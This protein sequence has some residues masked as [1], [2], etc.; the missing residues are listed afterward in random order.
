MFGIQ[1]YP[2]PP[3]LVKKMVNKL[4]FSKE[5]KSISLLE[6][7]AGKGNIID[8]FKCL[9]TGV[10]SV[11]KGMIGITITQMS[12]QV[13]EKG[14]IHNETNIYTEIQILTSEGIWV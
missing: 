13:F 11:E 1:F 7:S 5:T 9:Q 3:E 14:I 6:P 12:S 4:T 10:K 2:S 8:G